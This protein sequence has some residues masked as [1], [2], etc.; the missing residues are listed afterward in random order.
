MTI[1]VSNNALA[2]IVAIVF[3]ACWILGKF[4]ARPRRIL[5]APTVT[6]DLAPVLRE[7][8]E[9]RDTLAAHGGLHISPAATGRGNALNGA[10]EG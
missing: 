3:G 9:L 4:A 1:D 6:T 5:P 2:A 7:L 10:R 8:E